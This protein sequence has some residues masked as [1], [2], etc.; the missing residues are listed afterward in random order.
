MTS[1]YDGLVSD[2]LQNSEKYNPEAQAISYAILQEKQ[3]IMDEAQHT[4]TMAVIDLLPE[5]ILDVLAVEMRTP[6]YN[7]DFPIETK[8]T[9]IKGTLAFYAKLGTPSAVNWIIRSV[10]GNGSVEEWF[11]YGG[12][13]HHVRVRVKNDGTFRSLDVLDDFM[14][15][16][17]AVKRL[18]SWFE[19][20]IVET[21]LGET[22]AY[23]G[24]AMAMISKVPI[25][26]TPDTFDFIDELRTGGQMSA[27]SKIPVPQIADSFMFRDALAAGG[28]MS[29]V[30]RFPIPALQDNITLSCTGRVGAQG[31]VTVTI[32]V[33]EI[34]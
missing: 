12:E 22:T 20:I 32:P 8:R 18:S 30:V 4:R 31:A 21:D 5:Q 26:Q 9:L 1:L 23:L 28:Q 3:R 16:V 2:L 34:H 19:E 33:P 6:A 25:P 24:G 14:R 15:L 11:T 10:F 13:P 7:E 27:I 17:F 29:S